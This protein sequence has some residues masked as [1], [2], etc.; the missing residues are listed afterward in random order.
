M[1]T[2][3]LANA[4]CKIDTP[5]PIVPIAKCFKRNSHLG[6]PIVVIDFSIGKPFVIPGCDKAG[7]TSS[8][9]RG[10]TSD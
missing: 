5:I 4:A 10:L 7:A 9:A 6:G 3:L 2:V 1:V 8:P